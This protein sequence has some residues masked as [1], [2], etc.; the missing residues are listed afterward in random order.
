MIDPAR[1]DFG[2]SLSSFFSREF[3][4]TRDYSRSSYFLS[5]FLS[6]EMFLLIFFSFETYTQR[7]KER[8]QRSMMRPNPKK[9]INL[10]AR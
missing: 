1:V 2:A 9:C 8:R 6:R 10:V 4:L 5:L 3:F 7:P